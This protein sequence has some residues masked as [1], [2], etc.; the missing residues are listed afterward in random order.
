MP[1][2]IQHIM[3]PHLVQGLLIAHLG[4]LGA[5]TS[6]PP[7]SQTVSVAVAANF[8]KVHDELAQTFTEQTGIAVKSSVG[9]TGQ[10]YAQIRNGAPHH[11][12]LAADAER[13]RK[14]EDEGLG[15][16]GSRF[17]YA[18]GVLVLYTAAGLDLRDGDAIL[19]TA[20]F[21]HL[22]ICNPELAPYGAAAAEAL[23]SLGHW[24]R[25]EHRI[26]QGQSVTQA[27]QFIESGN[28]EAGLV[29]RSLVM[30]APPERVWPVP[31]EHHAPIQQD[32]V[33]LQRGA[34]HEAARAYLEFL[35]SGA[36]RAV[37]TENGYTVPEPGGA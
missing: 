6:P 7:E 1:Y 30:D 28:A 31:P 18:Q 25:L 29:A 12:F 4:L 32:A 17:T 9:S 34:E 27:H 11:L 15:V 8:A 14:L 35:Q 19:E 26:V 2:S 24:N 22:A 20:P 23:K 33:L 21:N 3:P 36:A 10:L 13:P 16:A 37:I 5:C